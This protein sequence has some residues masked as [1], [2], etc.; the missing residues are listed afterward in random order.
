MEYT[1]VSS[2][3]D[4][5]TG[6]IM[7]STLENWDRIRELKD[8]LRVDWSMLWKTRLD[9]EVAAEGISSR[10]F[11]SL[12]VDRGEILFASRDF[13]PVSFREIL[14]KQLGRDAAGKADPDPMVGGWRKF[15]KE[16]ITFKKQVTR[17]ERPETKFD[18][19]QQQR[20]NGRGWLNK[21][22]IL[23]KTSLHSFGY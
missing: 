10:E 20:K 5:K 7:A 3:W 19:S 2:I 13:K 4:V 12:F 1:Y 11:R 9:D 18:A 22:K 21:A 17:H 8:E 23:K 16:N 14:E 15:V 6:A